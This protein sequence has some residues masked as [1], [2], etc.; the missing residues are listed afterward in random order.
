LENGK[1]YIYINDKRYIQC[2]KLLLTLR[3]EHQFDSIDQMEFSN[4][5]RVKDSHETTVGITAEEE[6]TAHCSSLQ[7][8]AENNYDTKLL[9]RSISFPLLKKLY[10]VGDPIAQKIFV[11]ELKKRCENGHPRTILF[12]IEDNYLSYLGDNWFVDQLN[13][14]DSKVVE[15]LIT[16]IEK[17]SILH[18]LPAI[19]IFSNFSNYIYN[20]NERI[21]YIK[22]KKVIYPCVDT[23]KLLLIEEIFNPN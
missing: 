4:L 15:N 2:L 13:D 22:I 1:T 18:Y 23:A 19:D 21:F 7:A 16:W 10:E 8:F 3:K 5:H 12:L 6:F 20:K 9:H 14:P 17:N 11:S